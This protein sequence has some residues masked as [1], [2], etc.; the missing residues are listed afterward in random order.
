MVMIRVM[1]F[2]LRY[3]NP[4]DGPFAW[5]KRKELVAKLI[6]DKEVDLL[7]TQEGLSSMLFDLDSLLPGFS[8]VGESRCQGEE[9]EY[10]A[11]YYRK[12]RFHL[13][14]QHQSWLSET[15]DVIGSRYKDAALPRICTSAFLED[16]VS[17]RRL[18]VFNTH[19]DHEGEQARTFGARCVFLAMQEEVKKGHPSILT[20]DFNCTLRSTSLAPLREHFGSVLTEQD[21]GTFHGFTKS[22]TYP[23][24]DHIF[25]S[26]HLKVK[27]K[28]VVVS[29]YGGTY[30]SDHFPV[31]GVFEYKAEQKDTAFSCSALGLNKL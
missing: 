16:R 13:L 10:N 23:P 6:L 30:V 20:G 21:P 18:R 19:L 8:R 27:E 17:Q 4:A 26:H 22:A 1:S 5:E 12:D 2:N 3:Q 25:Y 31:L 29:S 9:G 11:I 15:P 24:I 28:E 7:G 14:C